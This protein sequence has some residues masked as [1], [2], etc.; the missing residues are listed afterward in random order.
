MDKIIIIND[1]GIQ[2]E[3]ENFLIANKKHI[4]FSSNMDEISLGQNP[5]LKEIV[6]NY[7]EKHKVKIH[8]KDNIRFFRANEIIRIKANKD[9]TLIFLINEKVDEIN[10]TIDQIE[11]QLKDFSFIR[12]HDDHIIN[13]SFIAKITAGRDIDIELMNGD[14]VPIEDQRK[15]YILN[16]LENHNKL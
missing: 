15:Q 7:E 1:S 3:L 8:S 2:S 6:R 11:N 14:I 13:T 4:R 12:I 9:K 16:S 10:E 5:I